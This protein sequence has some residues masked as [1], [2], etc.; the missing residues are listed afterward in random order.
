MDKPICYL[1]CGFLGAGKTTYS[2]Q[3]SQKTGAIHLNPDDYCM[4]LFSKEEYEKNWDRCF[5]ETIE[6]LWEK[7]TEYARQGKSII[8]DMGF[9][10]KQSR[11]EAI[12]RAIHSGFNPIIHYVYAPDST[13]KERISKRQGTIADYNFNHFDELKKRFEE[14]EEKEQ[15]V[16]I[17]NY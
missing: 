10:T 6:H 11:Y 7:A 12:E 8:F 5:G 14:P 17:K 9:W 15:Y 13:L 2:K 3:L 4:K 1:I 16:K